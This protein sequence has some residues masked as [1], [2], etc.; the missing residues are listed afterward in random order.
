M[1]LPASHRLVLSAIVLSA[2]ALGTPAVAQYDRD[3][4]YVPSPNGVPSD[5]YARPVPLYPGTPGGAVGTPIVPRGAIAQPSPTPRLS[6]RPETSAPLY[7]RDL[8]V[9]LRVEQC[10]ESWSKAL[11]MTPVEF[12]RRCARLQKR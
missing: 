6:P 11:G 8:P 1:T 10:G 2:I 3:G 12:R 9:P 5:P 4:R 7:P